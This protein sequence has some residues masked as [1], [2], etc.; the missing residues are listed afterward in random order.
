MTKLITK[1][2]SISKSALATIFGILTSLCT[3]WAVIDFNTFDIKKDWFKLIIIGMPAIGG[4]ISKIK[5]KE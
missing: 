1:I 3:A 2:K 4:Y 5:S